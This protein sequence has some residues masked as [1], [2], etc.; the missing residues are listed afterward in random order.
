[1]SPSQIR[2]FSLRTGDTVVGLIRQPREK[3]RF[4]AMLKVQTVNGDAPERK[5][6]MMPFETLIPFFP[7]QRLMLERAQDELSTLLLICDAGGPWPARLDCGGATHWQDV[8][9]SEDRHSITANNND[10]ELIVLLI[11]ER[12][13]EVTDMKRMVKGE[14]VSSTFDEPQTACAGRRN[15]H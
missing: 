12:P 1:M 3:E 13:E 11:D 8:D 4:F 10:I 5:K 2:R 15:G 7:T 6:A 9:S 14:V